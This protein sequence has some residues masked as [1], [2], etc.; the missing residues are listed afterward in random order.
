MLNS[1]AKRSLSGAGERGKQG[2]EFQFNKIKSSGDWL[3]NNM[4]VLNIIELKNGERQTLCYVHFTTNFK[5]FNN[6]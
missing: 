2:T 1:Q 6:K 3:H 4:N 5:N